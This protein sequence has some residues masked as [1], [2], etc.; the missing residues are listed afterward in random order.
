MYAPKHYAVNDR[1][2]MLDFIKSNGFGI[3]FSHTGSEPWPA[4]CP[5]SWMRTAVSKD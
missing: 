4:I 3:L 2:K 5:S 1:A